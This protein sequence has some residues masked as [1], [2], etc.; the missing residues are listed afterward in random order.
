MNKGNKGKK[1]HNTARLI[2][3]M[4]KLRAPGGCPWD[5]EQTLDSLKPYLVEEC[6]EVLDAIEAGDMD[7]LEEELGDLLLQ[8]VFQTEICRENGLFDFENVAGRIADK[9][10]RRHPH[11]FAEVKVKDS[12]EVLDNW[13]EIKKTEKKE[14]GRPL[15]SAID[16]VPRHIPALMR[17]YKLQKKAAA[18]GFDWADEHGAMEKLEEELAEFEEAV[19]E[20]DQAKM[21]EEMGDIL[22]SLVNVGRKLKLEPETALQETVLKFQKRFRKLELKLESE[23]RQLEECS[24]DELDKAW[25]QAKEDE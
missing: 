9:L 10:I 4:A 18:V 21:K 11:V 13:R 12:G 24:L 23:G 5:A 1:L 8:V 25:D 3:I 2:D 15:Q 6:G 7:E 20:Q 22:F 17:A 14:A 16:G 19:I